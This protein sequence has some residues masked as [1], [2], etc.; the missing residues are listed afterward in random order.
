VK[1]ILQAL[2]V[3][4]HVYIDAVTGKKVVA[5]IFH[6]LSLTKAAPPHPEA[7]GS[8]L[9]IKIPL[10]GHRA[11]SPFCY[12]SLTELRGEQPFSLRYVHLDQDKVVFHFEFTVSSKD[13]LQTQEIVLPLPTLPVDPSG[14]Y[15][16]ELLWNQE[17]LGSH[18]IN[19]DH[20]EETGGK[21]G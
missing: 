1:P 18:R 10:G 19:V 7:E 16:L 5:G 11:S 13:P 14:T 17:P 21:D 3:A 6:R 4:D 12:I 2:L 15:A 20:R 8:K 9:R